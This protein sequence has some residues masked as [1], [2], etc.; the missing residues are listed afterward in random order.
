MLIWKHLLIW[1]IAR[2]KNNLYF[3]GKKVKN[4]SPDNFTFLLTLSSV[5][6]NII[7]SGN[8]FYIVYENDSN[9]NI[10]TTKMDFEIDKD[11]FESYLMRVYM[12]KN[13][14]YYYDDTDDEE[15]G[16]T[17]TKFKNEA[18]MKTLKFFKGKNDEKSKYYLKDK[19]NVYFVDEENLEIRKV[20]NADYKTFQI[21]EYFYAKDKNN[22]YYK[23]KKLNNVNPN[24]FKIVESEVKYNNEFYKIDE[25]MN[26]IKMER[27]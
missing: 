6:D 5:P 17:L 21:I 2:D 16:R 22:V 3:Y 27:E 26:L 1:I 18:D 10:N 7:K 8:D 13:N 20:E 4:V 9:D 19:D 25:N 24:Y 15:K 11:T 12:D 23:G 14:F